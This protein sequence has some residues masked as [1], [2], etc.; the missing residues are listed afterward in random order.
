MDQRLANQ[1]ITDQ[2]ITLSTKGSGAYIALGPDLELSRCRV[3]FDIAAKN[4]ALSHVR[5]LDCEIVMKRPLITYRW[6]RCYVEDCR[7][8]GTLRGLD[9]GH[10]P[11]GDLFADGGL[12]RCDFSDA[13]LDGVRFIGTDMSEHILPAWP[14]FTIL[15]PRANG[16][17]LEAVS[18]P[19]DLDILASTA[20]DA[21]EE[22][23]AITEYAPS[24]VKQLGGDVD[25]LRRLLEPLPC[26]VIL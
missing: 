7:F 21:P 9:F 1:V 26:V 11:E 2:T 23:V 24:L 20:A 19:D 17:A 14:C 4:L 3:V 18:W 25:T 16:S 5:F 22:V 13:I 6:Y 8:S 15:A 10:W 12:V